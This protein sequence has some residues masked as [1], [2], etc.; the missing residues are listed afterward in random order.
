MASIPRR[1]RPL[2]RYLNGIRERITSDMRVSDVR[3]YYSCAA[4]QI[5]CEA[6]RDVGGLER[7]RQQKFSNVGAPSAMSRIPGMHIFIR[8]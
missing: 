2:L 3:A 6:R 8:R 5:C 7:A 1:G 4:A